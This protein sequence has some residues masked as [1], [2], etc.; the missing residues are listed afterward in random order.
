MALKSQKFIHPGLILIHSFGLII[1][2]AQKKHP[3]E[4]KRE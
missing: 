3:K 4:K 2:S 1:I